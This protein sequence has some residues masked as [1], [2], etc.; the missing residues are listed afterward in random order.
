MHEKEFYDKLKWLTFLRL[1]FTVM[2]LGSTIFLQMGREPSLLAQPLLF[3][4]GLTVF[5]FLL[6]GIYAW[7]LK[8]RTAHRM[9]AYIQVGFDTVIVSSIIYIT[10]G[11]SS[12]FS[13][14]YL[15]VAIYSSMFLFR[16]GSIGISLFCG[17]Q[18]IT[19]VML[20]FAGLLHPAIADVD[21]LAM[22]T[23][24]RQVVLKI[25]I[26]AIACVAVALLSSI[27]AEQARRTRRELVTM[28][29]H[30]KRV[31][32]MAAVGEMAAGLAHEIRNPLA[33]L[34]GSIQLLREDVAG[35]HE[36]DKLM[37]IILREAN[38]LSA[39]VSDFLLFAR[40]PAGKPTVFELDKA[41][42][43]ILALF[44]RDTKS[45][46]R[47]TIQK[48]FVAD[49]WIE[50]DPSHF[51]QILWN[52]LLNAA[53]AIEN[54]GTIEVRMATEHPSFV[55]VSIRDDGCGIPGQKMKSIFDP[56]Y[57]T[58][59]Q[60]TGLGLSVVHSILDSYGYRL[61]VQSEVGSGT[62]MT[63]YLKPIQAPDTQS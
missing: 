10:G 56:F 47:V 12:V 22:N 41:L 31:E 39:L 30:V 45:S 55:Q 53:E 57:T 29:G 16:P 35:N 37:R 44:E 33:S 52:I 60:G 26:T 27:L 36:V 6:S 43:E 28:E 9:L 15:V 54:K 13:F 50:M 24:W 1:V 5:I 19:L 17:A 61:D 2:L 11:F 14:L 40:P 62:Q 21:T 48:D 32:K 58:K 46:Q 34:S 51:R 7:V 4:Y 23:D 38:R 20:E 59:P 49:V 18:Y 25:S 3:I 8:Y 42:A 63:L